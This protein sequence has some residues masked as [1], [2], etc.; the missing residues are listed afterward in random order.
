MGSGKSESLSSFPYFCLSLGAAG[1][2]ALPSPSHF[3]IS[4]GQE[5][6]EEGMKRTV[7]V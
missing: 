4:G 2:A 3:R 1:G 6:Q 7:S 5:R